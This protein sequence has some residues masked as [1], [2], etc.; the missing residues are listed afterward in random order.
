MGGWGGWGGGEAGK[1]MGI[2]GRTQMEGQQNARECVRGVQ[3]Q[4]ETEIQAAM[5]SEER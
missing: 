1:R 5:P 3:A 4:T 2:E